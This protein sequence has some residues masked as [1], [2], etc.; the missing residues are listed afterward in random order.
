LEIRAQVKASQA[1]LALAET[2]LSDTNL[3]CPSPGTVLT[4]I[5]EVGSVIAAGEPVFTVALQSPVWIRCYVAEPDLGYIFPGM[6]A[7]IV[8]D[9]K[10]SPR[11]KGHIGFIS[12]VA[13]F[14]PK[15]VET[16]QLRTDLVYRLRVIVDNPDEGLRQGMPVTILLKKKGEKNS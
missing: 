3:Y 9:T 4:R 6:E 5:K 14:T 11:Y 1:S 16:T 12:S 10:G 8:T 7:E 13:E 2:E 15:N